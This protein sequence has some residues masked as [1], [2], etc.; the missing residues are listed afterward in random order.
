MK[1]FKY[2]EKL[3]RYKVL[4]QSGDIEKEAVKSEHI[5]DGAVTSDK[6]P[7]GVVTGEKLADKSIEGRSL[8]DKVIESRHLSDDLEIDTEHIADDAITEGKIAEGAVTAGKIEDNAVKSRNIAEGAVVA[9][10]I[11]A[12]A[13]ENRNLAPASVTEG[14]LAPGAVTSDKLAPEIISQLE[15]ITDPEPTAGSVLPVQS[16]GV[17]TEIDRLDKNIIRIHND[18]D[19]I[20]GDIDNFLTDGTLDTYQGVGNVA[21]LYHRDIENT[22]S[23]VL[24]VDGGSKYFIKGQG[25]AYGYCY[26]VLDSSNIIL[27]SSRNLNNGSVVTI[28]ENGVRLVVNFLTNSSY[29]YDLK[30]VTKRN[31]DID[32]ISEEVGILNQNVVELTQNAVTAQKHINKINHANAVADVIDNVAVGEIQTLSESETMSVVVLDSQNDD[33]KRST[34]YTFKGITAYS[35]VKQDNSVYTKRV[36]TSASNTYTITIP[37]INGIKLFLQIANTRLG[38]S[39][40]M[41]EGD[42]VE[43]PDRFISYEEIRLTDS[44]GENVLEHIKMSGDALYD[45]SVVEAKYGNDSIPTRAIPQSTIQDLKWDNVLW[46]KKLVVCGDSFTYGTGSGRI[47]SSGIY[48]GK[49]A[50]QIANWARFI[51][52]RNNMTLF[53][54]AIGGST[55]AM[56]LAWINDQTKTLDENELLHI[57]SYKRYLNQ[58]FDDADYIIIHLGINDGAPNGKL[59]NTD[60]TFLSDAYSGSDGVDI[61]Q[62]T[63]TDFDFYGAYNKVIR[64]ILTRNPRVK[65]GIVIPERGSVMKQRAIVDVAIRWGIPYIYQSGDPHISLIG[66]GTAI[67]ATYHGRLNTSYWYEIKFVNK[68]EYSSSEYDVWSSSQTYSTGDR[69]KY[70]YFDVCTGKNE[71]VVIQSLIDNNDKKPIVTMSDEA[72]EIRNRAFDS[73]YGTEEPDNPTA[74]GSPYHPNYYGQIYLSTVYENF[75]RSL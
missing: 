75:L 55:M 51:A 3:G 57:F 53:N 60:A 8:A 61:T 46:G 26:A 23:C 6:L 13:V 18:A 48:G 9:G 16:G 62:V 50:Q 31:N 35:M 4:V 17:K 67:Q 20:E 5:A 14:N 66:V 10:N 38:V 49:G 24:N 56:P 43:I 70:T 2:F 37:N 36:A 15:T 42:S 74:A 52:L 21:T 19:L 30:K 65:I 54:E 44:N 12:N 40:M 32:V 41:L 11:A 59:D 27:E 25:T 28:P 7:D 68:E 73:K 63:H 39:A 22:K 34:K 45:G 64:S 58:N 71:Y 72:Y 33:I 29:G 47:P 69:V 1:L